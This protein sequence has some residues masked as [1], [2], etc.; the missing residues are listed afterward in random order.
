MR[1]VSSFIIIAVAGASLAA[2]SAAGAQAAGAP[3]VHAPTG[4]TVAGIAPPPAA[5]AAPAQRE[6]RFFSG[7][8]PVV[9]LPDGRV[10]ADFGRGY[11]QI[12][13]SCAAP[14]TYGAPVS[15]AVGPPP[16]VVQPAAVQ[17]PAGVSQ[18]VP[19]AP[20]SPVQP[21]AAQSHMSD[22]SCWAADSRGQIL[23][24]HP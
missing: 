7:G 9:V 23:V 17:P 18:P 10:F 14:A 20:P 15:A 13:R 5:V 6:R 1:I 8:V 12:V 22:L 4:G 24:A 21:T 16:A 19:Y 3:A 2:V 11:E